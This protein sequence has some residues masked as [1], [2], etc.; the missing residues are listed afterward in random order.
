MS[1]RTTTSP[2]AFPKTNKFL[3]FWEAKL[4]GKLF[5]ITVT[6][7]DLVGPADLSAVDGEFKL[8]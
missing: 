8:Q 1:G 6:H 7:K 4:H 2:R 3:A 5:R